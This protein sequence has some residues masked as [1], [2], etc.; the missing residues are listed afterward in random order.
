MQELADKDAL[1]LQ[2]VL[3]QAITEQRPKKIIV[4]TH[5]PPFK[6]VCLHLGKVSDDDWLPYFGSKIVGD[7]LIKIASEHTHIDFLVFCGHTH[8]KGVYQP[9]SNLMIEA[10]AAE[11][12]R[13]E[14]QKIIFI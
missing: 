10:G 6:E 1:C 7:V 2:R 3:E 13:P 8:S 11:Y 14:I 12:C 5:V 4:L 9:L